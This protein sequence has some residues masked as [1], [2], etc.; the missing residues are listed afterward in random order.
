MIWQSKTSPA[1]TYGNNGFF[2]NMD[3]SSPGTDTSG[4]NNTFT[5]TGT[6]TLTQDNAS[7]NFPTINKTMQPMQY[8]NTTLSAWTTRINSSGGDYTLFCS[9]R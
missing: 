4:N 1:V 8:S 9:L 5:A 7:N 6:P 2:L 3:T